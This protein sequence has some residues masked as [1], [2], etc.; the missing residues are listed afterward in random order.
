MVI[1]IENKN[2]I[3]RHKQ[4]KKNK[5]KSDVFAH[6]LP[7]CA[8]INSQIQVLMNAIVIGIALCAIDTRSM[9]HDKKVTQ[10]GKKQQQ[11]KKASENSKKQTLL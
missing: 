7:C 2:V 11:N 1:T 10:I 6:Q 3:F 8:E 5:P 4:T 9:T